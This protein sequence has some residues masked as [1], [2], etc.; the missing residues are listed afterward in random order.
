MTKTFRNIFVTIA[1]L[2]WAG[3]A[4][5]FSI[6]NVTATGTITNGMILTVTGSF[7]T[8]FATT[9]SKIEDFDTGSF[10]PNL[11]NVT[12]QLVIQAGNQRHPYST[13]HATSGF[14]HPGVDQGD[15]SYLQ[16][17]NSNLS[18]KWRVIW[19]TDLGADWT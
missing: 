16:G 3:D 7:E 9:V 2:A 18:D 17:N 13:F 19:R 6:S 12:T 4:G 1:A 14:I 5:A 8:S 15:Q 10:V 11:W